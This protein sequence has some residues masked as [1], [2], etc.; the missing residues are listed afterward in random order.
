MCKNKLTS[1]LSKTLSCLSAIVFASTV[2]ADVDPKAPDKTVEESSLK[3][4][5][6]QVTATKRVTNLNDTSLAISAY[7]SKMMDDLGISTGADYLNLTP[8]LSYNSNPA[9]IYIRGVGLQDNQPGVDS[10]VALYVDGIY[11][12]NALDINRSSFDTQRIEIVRGP[13]GT[14]FGRNATGGA[15]SIVT[16]R[17][18]I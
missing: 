9:R 12:N 8:S 1:K 18:K 17:P 4:E 14:L 13:Q 5:V 16:K 15:V 11:S 2:A 6:I 10:G 7:D 3:W